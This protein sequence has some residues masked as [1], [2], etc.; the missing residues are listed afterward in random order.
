MRK[1]AV[2]TALAVATATVA[3]VSLSTAASASAVSTTELYGTI[4]TNTSSYLAPNTQSTKVHADL[5]SGEQ[6]VVRCFTQ[7][8]RVEGSSIWIR[9]G[10]DNKLAFVPRAYIDA[11]TDLPYC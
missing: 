8:E 5:R 7:G 11:P 10:K 2:I 4:S 9:M 1:T 6:V 3:A